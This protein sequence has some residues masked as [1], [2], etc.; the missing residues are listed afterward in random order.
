MGIIQHL[1]LVVVAR[2]PG[3]VGQ[4]IKIQQCLRLRADGNGAGKGQPGRRIVDSHRLAPCG[5]NKPTDRRSSAG[6]GTSPD[7]IAASPS[8]VR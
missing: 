3:E 2:I 6:V 5:L 4:R 1:S 8:R 7:S